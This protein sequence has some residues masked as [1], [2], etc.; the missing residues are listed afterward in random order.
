[1]LQIPLTSALDCVGDNEAYIRWFPLR[2]PKDSVAYE[3]DNGESLKPLDS[4]KETDR[5][6]EHF[7]TR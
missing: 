2:S 7:Y 3:G 1:M 4:E 5:G 6:F